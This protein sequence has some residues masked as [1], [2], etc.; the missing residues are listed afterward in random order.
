MS[1]PVDIGKKI[2]GYNP[3]L[4]VNSKV[5]VWNPNQVHLPTELAFAPSLKQLS[6]SK[7]NDS[8]CYFIISCPGLLHVCEIHFPKVPK[9]L[10]DHLWWSVKIFSLLH[11]ALILLSLFPAEDQM[12]P[13][14]VGPQ[15]CLH[16]WMNSKEEHRESCV[17]MASCLIIFCLIL[18]IEGLCI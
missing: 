10:L 17:I 16:V 12:L 18:I 14:S 9:C 3:L 15:A 5:Q 6:S 4:E 11:C 8:W 7:Y 13:Q 2:L 1:D